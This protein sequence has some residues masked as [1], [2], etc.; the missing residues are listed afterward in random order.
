MVAMWHNFEVSRSTNELWLG[1]VMPMVRLSLLP[2]TT[3]A[4][5]RRKRKRVTPPFIC[6]FILGHPS[7][8]KVSLRQQL[9]APH[10]AATMSSASAVPPFR[11]VMYFTHLNEQFLD[12]V[13]PSRRHPRARSCALMS[14]WPSRHF[15]PDVTSPVQFAPG[16]E[17][18]RRMLARHHWCPAPLWRCSRHT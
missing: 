4:D 13:C 5:C 9:V 12:E 6:N 15:A 8:G 10:L 2:Q 1:R 3:C 16:V 11:C 14:T 18:I 17:R 7:N